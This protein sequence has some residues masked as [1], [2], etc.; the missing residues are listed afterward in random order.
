MG[1]FGPEIRLPL[2]PLGEAHRTT[3]ATELRRLGLLS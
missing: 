1:M 2:V 3:L